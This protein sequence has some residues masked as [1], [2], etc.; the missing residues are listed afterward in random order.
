MKY[1]IEKINPIGKMLAEVME[2]AL[3]TEGKEESLSEI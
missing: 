2:D 3:K 1:S